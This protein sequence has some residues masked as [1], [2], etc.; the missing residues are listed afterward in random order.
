M[1]LMF[2]SFCLMM[3]HLLYPQYLMNHYFLMFLM[4]HCLSLIHEYQ[5]YLLNR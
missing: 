1:T 2:L 3:T 5:Q 4:N